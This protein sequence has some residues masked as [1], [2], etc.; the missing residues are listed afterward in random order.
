MKYEA[1]D[2]LDLYKIK[3]EEHWYTMFQPI[4]AYLGNLKGKRILDIGC[5]S[6][7]LANEL[8][9]TAQQVIGLDLSKQWIGYCQ[10]KYD[11]KNLQFI[12]ANAHDLKVFKDGSFD[13][14]IMNMVLPNIYRASEI[15]K[16]FSEIKRVTKNNGDFIFSDLHPLC[17]MTPKAGNRQEK[18]SKDFSYF[19][20][21]AKFSAIVKLPQGREIEFTDS[22]WT[23]NF[24][25]EELSKLNIYIKR[26][27][28]S[29]YPKNAP[30]KFYRYAFP[31]YI[32]FC[33]KKII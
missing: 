18:Y 22:H 23:L 32:I 12:Q 1:Q 25:T 4:L 26:I 16:I 29:N 28:E 10:D 9:K 3:V 30:K 6:G 24:Y 31:E 8:A 17:V 14:V 20:D 5:G 2:L 27:I 15:R 19:K 21:G 11:R 7:E 13:V 33:C